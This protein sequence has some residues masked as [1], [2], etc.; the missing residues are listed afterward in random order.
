MCLVHG[1]QTGM[2]VYTVVFFDSYECGVYFAG[3][4]V[5]LFVGSSTE[6]T[7]LTTHGSADSQPTFSRFY[8]SPSSISDTSNDTE[9]GETEMLASEWDRSPSPV[10]Q[11]QS[12]VFFL[13]RS[14]SDNEASAAEKSTFIR[15]A[16]A[17][18]SKPHSTASTE[19]GNLLKAMFRREGAPSCVPED[20][21]THHGSL[22][23][24]VVPSGSFG[25]AVLPHVSSFG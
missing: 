18:A 8:R 6:L 2:L 9:A 25:G 5:S 13:E 1:R 12:S 10:S 16:D 11:H 14:F 20:R 22:S 15:R 19:L 21:P 24:F 4:E 17:D 7:S 23:S 3:T